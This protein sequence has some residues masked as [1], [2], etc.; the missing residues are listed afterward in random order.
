[1]F[2]CHTLMSRIVVW[3]AHLVTSSL[4]VGFI[5]PLLVWEGAVIKDL[6]SGWKVG[7]IREVSWS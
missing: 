5:F 1:M 4:F 7:G 6:E 3:G 2:S